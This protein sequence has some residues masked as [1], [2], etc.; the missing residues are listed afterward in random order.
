M[1]SQ[2]IS[3]LNAIE[4]SVSGS[5]ESQLRNLLMLSLVPGIGPKIFTQLLEHFGDAET[6][7]TCEP[8]SLRSVPG[9]G[10]KLAREVSLATKTI[11]VDRYLELC[12]QNSISIL[13]LFNPDYPK[14]LQEIHNPPPV[15]FVQGEMLEQDTLAIAIV[16]SRHA[17]YY[18]KRVAEQFARGLATAG[19][20]I[21]SGLARG[22]DAAAHRG[23]L[24]AGGRTIAVLGSGVL[25]VYP[26][27]HNELAKQVA[28]NG[29]VISEMT[30][31]HPPKSGSFPQR[32]RIVTG[33]SLGTVI[34][35]A[36]H[37]SGALISARLAM[38]QGRE[39]FAV[40]GPIDSR[41]SKGC[42]KLIRDGA[43]LV[44]SVDDILEELGPL[45]SPTTAEDGNVV[46]H[47]MELQLNDQ[48]KLI[49]NAIE[50]QPTE[51]EKIADSTGVPVARML[52]TI[53]A[54]EV[55]RLIRRVSGTA[56][57]RC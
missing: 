43:K 45:V 2:P 57:I 55:R 23:A 37:R 41:M 29:A 40:P 30:P 56:V 17:T 48:E 8:N 10:P 42:H 52:S 32:N 21:V 24:A 50:Q 12:Q 49:L 44:E 13:D 18:G 3:N 51:L 19:Y 34:V 22:I 4:G 27:E 47:P 9:V 20:T 39:V 54:L 33:L 36:A 31:N 25:N 53:S 14:Q 26:A 7:L 1:S 11:K 35:E 16:G 6:V 15:M 28:Q 5:R 46:H 38:E